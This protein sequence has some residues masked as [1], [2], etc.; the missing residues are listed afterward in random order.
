MVLTG[1]C[2]SEK[3]VGSDFFACKKDVAFESG[4]LKKDVEPGA[5]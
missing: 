2:G 1:C 5:E 3:D 4:G